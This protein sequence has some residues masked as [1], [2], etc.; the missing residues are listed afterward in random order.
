[1]RWKDEVGLHLRSILEIE[2]ANAID[3]ACINDN[4][5]GGL[6][7]PFKGDQTHK[8]EWGKQDETKDEK[9]RSQVGDL[10]NKREGNQ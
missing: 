4:C 8:E 7:H 10:P 1:M 6:E 3:A 5:I 2:V 9:G